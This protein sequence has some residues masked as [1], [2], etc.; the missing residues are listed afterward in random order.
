M[1][2]VNPAMCLNLSTGRSTPSSDGKL[3]HIVFRDMT[4]PMAEVAKFPEG[5]FDFLAP[6]AQM[7]LNAAGKRAPLRASG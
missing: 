7:R 6:D 3:S 5:A 1:M 4:N 2:F